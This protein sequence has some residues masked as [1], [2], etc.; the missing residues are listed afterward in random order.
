MQRETSEVL[1]DDWEE[2]GRAARDRYF[3]F[4]TGLDL[5]FRHCK[6]FGED[7]RGIRV[8]FDLGQHERSVV[9]LDLD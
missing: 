7:V 5:G 4:A 3:Q 8:D 2:G 6:R 1:S 9:K